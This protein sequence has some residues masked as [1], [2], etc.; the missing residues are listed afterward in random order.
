MSPPAAPDS[1]DRFLG[2]LL[3]GAIGDSLGYPIEFVKSADEIV[4][5][6]GVA[7]PDALAYAGAAV[8][9][10]DTQMTL[11]SA[12]ALLRARAARAGS[13]AP[14]ALGAY[15]RWYAT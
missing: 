14:F 1:R 3:A 13:I 8:V 4:A 2:C 7:P 9:S 15:Q 6:F 10:D 5:R 11:F 12:D